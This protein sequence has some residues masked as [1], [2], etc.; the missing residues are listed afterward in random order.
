MSGEQ[1]TS[2][3]SAY[4]APQQLIKEEPRTV[5]PSDDGEACAPTTSSET[6]GKVPTLAKKLAVKC[7]SE[8]ALIVAADMAT[9]WTP[10]LWKEQLARIKDMRSSQDAPVDTM[11]CDADLTKSSAAAASMA[12]PVRRFHVLVSLMLSAQTRD[13]V[14]AKAMQ[15][16]HTLPLTIDT[17]LATDADALAK[18]IYPVSF[19]KVVVNKCVFQIKLFER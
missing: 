2:S 3:S 6:N 13:E 5:T 7:K 17:V 15:Q 8:S 14:T 16:L 18:L 12:P 10:P 1:Q 4:F 9:K 19:Y 11:G